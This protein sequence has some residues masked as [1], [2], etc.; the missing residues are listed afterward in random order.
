MPRNVKRKTKRTQGPVIHQLNLDLT[1]TRR[2]RTRRRYMVL[3]QVFQITV[4][5]SAVL[6]TVVMGYHAFRKAILQNDHF[7]LRHLVWETD[8]R[9]TRGETLAAAGLREG[10][11]LLELDL[12]EVRARIEDLP[13]VDQ[14]ELEK[15]LPDRLEIR[16]RERRPL[17]WISCPPAGIRPRS[18]S[19]GLLVDADGR[20]FR[21][22]H[23][24]PES[25]N[26]PTLE[27]LEGGG[28]T[29]GLR[30]ED[31]DA[32]KGLDLLAEIARRADPS[33]PVIDSICLFNGYTLEIRTR[34]GQYAWLSLD[35]PIED[36][37]RLRL[38]LDEFR[39]QGRSVEFA[40]LLPR[41]NIAIR[42]AGDG[43]TAP[44]AR[45]VA[46]PPDAEPTPES[47]NLRTRDLRAILNRG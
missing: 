5:A 30:L 39:S 45:L 9:L 35:N 3:R 28:L 42:L 40:N 27:V 26:L 33:D 21:C 18:P 15:M 34:G 16:I 20:L 22:R 13:Q 4:L 37:Q 31:P 12:V 11:N 14:V 24:A 29:P 17:A 8:G 47:N 32:R 19:A 1:E 43:T 46:P 2:G 36:F 41:R 38:V 25:V 44:R 6:M 7:A 23:L 10:L